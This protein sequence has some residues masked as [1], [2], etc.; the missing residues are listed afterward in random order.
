MGK[1]R[2]LRK[3]Q[4]FK[5]YTAAKIILDFRRICFVWRTCMVHYFVFGHGMYCS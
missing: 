5:N 2:Y 3:E 1:I 4:L